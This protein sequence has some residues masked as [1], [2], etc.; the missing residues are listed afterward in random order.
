MGPAA[1]DA[2]SLDTLQKIV[3]MSLPS[4]LSATSAMDKGILLEIALQM[5]PERFDSSL[6]YL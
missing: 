6:V 5:E 3:P 1:T 2:P 4:R